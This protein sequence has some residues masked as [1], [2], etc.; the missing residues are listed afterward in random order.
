MKQPGQPK[1]F[2]YIT[3]NISGYIKLIPYKVI[4]YTQ[5]NSHER[6]AKDGKRQSIKVLSVV[7]R[8]QIFYLIGQIYS[9]VLYGFG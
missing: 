1:V 8:V 4:K 9:Q 2:K 5:S 6:S 3:L 7:S